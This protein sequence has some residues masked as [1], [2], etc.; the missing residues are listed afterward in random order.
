MTSR[1]IVGLAITA[2]DQDNQRLALLDSVAHE[3]GK[4]WL[5]RKARV[6]ITANRVL[7]F[8]VLVLLQSTRAAAQNPE[9]DPPGKLKSEIVSRCPGRKIVTLSD[10][11]PDDRNFFQKRAHR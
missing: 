7:G 8:F 10:L 4:G 3:K 1:L 6:K 5:R 2:P 9:C 11:D